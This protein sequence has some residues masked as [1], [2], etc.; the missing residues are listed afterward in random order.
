MPSERTFP[1]Y[2]DRAVVHRVA[3]P[4]ADVAA[5][6][7]P[8]ALEH[9]A[10]HRAGPAEHDDRATLLIDAGASA[11]LALDDQVTAAHRRPRERARVRVDHDDAGHHVLAHRPADPSLDVDLG[12]SITPQP[13]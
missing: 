3:E 13:K 8:S 2:V 5:E 1:G 6:D 10:G 4:C 12:P 11:D 7:H 9:E